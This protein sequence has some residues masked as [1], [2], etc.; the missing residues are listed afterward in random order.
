[1]FVEFFTNYVANNRYHV[2][3]ALLILAIKKLSF[4]FKINFSKIII[5][6]FKNLVNNGFKS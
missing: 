5:M 3:Q 2:I 1:M 6:L 4:I